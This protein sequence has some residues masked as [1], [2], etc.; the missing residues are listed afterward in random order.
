MTENLE[1]MLA[2]PLDGERV[3]AFL[4]SNPDFV[5]EDAELFA[6]MAQRE[7]GEGI[8]DLGAAARAK[9]LSELTIWPRSTARFPAA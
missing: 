7:T 9:L 1:G 3:R 2:E 8:I 6:Q 5:R 4:L